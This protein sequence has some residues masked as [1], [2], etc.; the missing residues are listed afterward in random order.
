MQST[1]IVHTIQKTAEALYP[2][3]SYTLRI[4][5]QTSRNSYRLWHDP[6]SSPRRRFVGFMGFWFEEELWDHGSHAQLHHLTME[7]DWYL[8][9]IVANQPTSTTTISFTSTTE[10]M[11]DQ[12]MMEMR[13]NSLIFS[14]FFLSK[15]ANGKNQV[16]SFSYQICTPLIETLISS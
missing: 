11:T 12:L 9:H 5:L 6:P 2:H 13:N 4:F 3:T 14:F 15:I 7:E 10:Q 1:V 16:L 8:S